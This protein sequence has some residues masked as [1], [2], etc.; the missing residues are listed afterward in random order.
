MND[1]CPQHV[2][3]RER[4]F[5][6]SLRLDTIADVARHDR[7]LRREATIERR[8]DALMATARAALTPEA[9]D[10]AED[11]GMTL[12]LSGALDYAIHDTW[13]P[14]GQSPLSEQEA[15]VAKLVAAGHTNRQIA[16][17]LRLSERTVE[18]LLR[19][20]RKG[21]GLRSRAQL[22]AWSVRHLG[23]S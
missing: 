13:Q 15:A 17:R 6:R 14:R 16:T 23:Q 5:A 19:G 11:D 10:R 12:A 2:I 22:A 4:D 20:I 7:K 18:A 9:A 3:S 1:K 21:L 8:R